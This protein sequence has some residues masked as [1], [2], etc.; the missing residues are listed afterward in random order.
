MRNSGGHLDHLALKA[1]ELTLL[2]TFLK[3]YLPDTAVWAYGS[4]VN[5]SAHSASDLD[6]VAFASSKQCVAI[7]ELREALEESNLPF[8]VDLFIWD[9]VPEAFRTAIR[10]NYIEIQ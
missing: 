6:I 4:R 5:G 8:R 10:K 2:Q 3:R 1:S 7:A 9:Q